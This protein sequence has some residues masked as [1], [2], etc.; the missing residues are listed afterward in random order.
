MKERE[1]WRTRRGGSDHYNYLTLLP[2]KTEIL[3][4]SITRSG[5]VLKRSRS[6]WIEALIRTS[7]PEKQRSAANQIICWMTTVQKKDEMSS[8]TSRLARKLSRSYGR[9]RIIRR[10]L[11]QPG[12]VLRSRTRYRSGVRFRRCL[13]RWFPRRSDLRRRP[14]RHTRRRRSLG[15][16][17]M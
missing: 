16:Q 15:C 2:S 10:N 14:S 6:T 7:Q 3:R 13:F 12:T 17:R 8:S 11:L 4:S 5:R 9:L 1:L